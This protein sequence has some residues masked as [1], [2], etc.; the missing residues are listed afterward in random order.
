MTTENFT[1]LKISD[2]IHCSN[3]NC[4]SIEHHNQIDELYIKVRCTVDTIK[5]VIATI[6]GTARTAVTA[7]K[8]LAFYLIR[9]LLLVNEKKICILP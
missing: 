2:V 7:A 1:Q 5:H 6:A 4:N 9:R 8:Y 3:V